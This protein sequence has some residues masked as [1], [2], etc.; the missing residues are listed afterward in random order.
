M[1]EIKFICQHFGKYIVETKYTWQ[2]LVQYTLE[3]S[4]SYISMME[5]K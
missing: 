2:K 1:G 3:E 5:N 4:N